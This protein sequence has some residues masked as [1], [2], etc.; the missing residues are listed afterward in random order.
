MTSAR[1]KKDTWQ[2]AGATGMI[3]PLSNAKI[4]VAKHNFAA[5]KRLNES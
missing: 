3:E 4:Q 2:T 1:T 5:T